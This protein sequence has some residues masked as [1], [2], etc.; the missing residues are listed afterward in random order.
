MGGPVASG[1]G[2]A[3][4]AEADGLPGKDRLKRVAAGLCEEDLRADP[5]RHR[6]SVEGQ[7]L[8]KIAQSRL[9]Q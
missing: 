8:G 9:D 5:L 2:I 3:R 7:P 6:Q 4:R 1:H